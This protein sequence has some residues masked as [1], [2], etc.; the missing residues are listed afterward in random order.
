VENVDSRKWSES[1]RPGGIIA[2]I[3]PD[4]PDWFSCRG[5]THVSFNGEMHVTF[6]SFDEAFELGHIFYPT[7]VKAIET[8]GSRIVSFQ[9]LGVPAPRDFC[10]KRLPVV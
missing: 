9:L 5:Y 6:A 1:C 8:G 3:W 4:S 10:W 2:I 7:A